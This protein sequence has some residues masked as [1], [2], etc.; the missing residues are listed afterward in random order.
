MNLTVV[1]VTGI[2]DVRTGDEAIVL[3]P[4]ITAANHARLARTIPYEILCGIHPCG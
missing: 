2:H 1:D 4:G 3:G